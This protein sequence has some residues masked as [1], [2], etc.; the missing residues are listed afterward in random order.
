VR[1]DEMQHPDLVIA[2]DIAVQAGQGVFADRQ[3]ERLG[4]SDTA[5]I[6][7]RKILARE[8]RAIL[9][10]RP[11]KTWTVAPEDVVPTLGF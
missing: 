8:L 3:H 11:S 6:V 5:I 1:F 10:G 2:Q 4:K 9:E 7:W